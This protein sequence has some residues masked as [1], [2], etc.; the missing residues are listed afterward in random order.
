MYTKYMMAL[1]RFPTS[2]T[3][4]FFERFPIVPRWILLTFGIFPGWRILDLINARW[5]QIWVFERLFG[6][7]R[8]ISFPTTEGTFLEEVERKRDREK[9]NT[10]HVS[11]VSQVHGN[12]FSASRGN[13]RY[14]CDAT[15][16]RI[17]CLI[18][19]DWWSPLL[20][21]RRLPNECWTD[22]RITNCSSCLPTK[23]RF[24][25]PIPRWL[26]LITTWLHTCC[27]VVANEGRGSPLKSIEEKGVTMKKARAQVSRKSGFLLVFHFT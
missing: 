10:T 18:Q 9:K 22:R 14:Q 23:M 20:G 11:L 16:A 17:P 19:T 2:P 26:G 25:W 13:I 3:I 4:W 1:T 5:N 7:L 21:D 8:K 24:F 15:W 12:P 27:Q 6:P